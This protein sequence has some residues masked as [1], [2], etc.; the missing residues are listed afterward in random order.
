MTDG[1]LWLS[2]SVARRFRSGAGE[3]SSSCANARAA[4]IISTNPA[5]T[6]RMLF[7]RSFS[8]VRAGAKRPALHSRDAISRPGTVK[9]FRASIHTRRFSRS[10][11]ELSPSVGEI[12]RGIRAVDVL[13]AGPLPFTAGATRAVLSTIG[14]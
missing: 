2:E 9:P 10:R 6:T 12:R 8:V 3:A 1:S 11:A 13:L 14:P 5:I 7:I 4:A